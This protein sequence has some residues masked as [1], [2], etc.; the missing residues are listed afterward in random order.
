MRVR[1][2]LAG[3]ALA[4]ASCAGER[5][6]APPAPG[7][8]LQSIADVYLDALAARDPLAVYFTLTDVMTPDH[9]ALPDISPQAIA[10]FQSKEDALL[11]ELVKI[12]P[13]ALQSRGDWVV[14]QSL[15]EAMEASVGL[16]QCHQEWWSVS[17]M[18]GWQAGLGDLAALQPVSTEEERA[19]ALSRWSKLPAYI[20]QDRAN[21]E[22]GL[23]QGY[24]APR[25]VVRKV[26]AQLDALL[27]APVERNPYL[28]F[29][30]RAEDHPEFQ[31]AA[32]ALFQNEIAPAIAAYR[33]Y[34]RDG[35]L[36]AAR[37]ELS[38]SVLPD[39]AA[40]YE[41]MLRNYHTAEIGSRTTYE[42]GRDTV[43][44]NR[45]GAIARAEALL[46]ESDWSAIQARVKAD[47]A[48]RFTGEQELIDFT[49]AFVPLTRERTAAF[50]AHM[51]K[52]EMTVEPYPD[53]LKGTG[54]PS[55]YES[56]P[57]ARGAATY[58]IDTDDWAE[59]TRGEAEIVAVHEGWPG[60]HMQI[61]TALSL[62][63]IHPVTRLTSSTAYIEGWA[64]YA[65]A[66]AEEAGLYQNGYGEISRRM[67]PARGMVVDPGLHVFGWTNEQAIEFLKESGRHTDQTARDLLDR[68]A[69]I[70]GQLTAYDTGGLEIM[71]LRSEAEARL[72]ER[73]DIREFHAR[74]LEN[75][76]IPLGALRAHVEAW[77]AEEAARG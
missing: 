56:N 71:A 51:P 36:P 34:L 46:G 61:A 64:R 6:K 77:I 4:A 57:D 8:D 31:A 1:L 45:A 18:T 26:I 47:P 33:D 59:Q 19:A 17:H 69:V 62:Q 76:A 72:G 75:G 3:L 14:Y 58:R 53:Y 28:D 41:A 25:S 22:A 63:G 27:A 68:I 5:Q 55:R 52:Q 66:L 49:R 38:I 39:G 50:F 12:D 54:Q 2:I 43:E 29:A 40:C 21:L 42:R 35:Y 9:A 37:E 10:A 11:A 65:E 70:P 44:A 74:I 30:T 23:E 24:S 60:H 32:R 16:R 48:N 73:F 7:A 15:K 67:W 20:A 13:A